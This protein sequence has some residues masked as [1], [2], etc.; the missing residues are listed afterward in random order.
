MG[1]IIETSLN[2][3]GWLPVMHKTTMRSKRIY[4]SW[5]YWTGNYYTTRWDDNCTSDSGH[6]L[7]TSTDN[8]NGMQGE[9]GSDEYEKLTIKDI[10]ER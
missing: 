7:L 5:K 2:M 6:H 8:G 3:R 1:L 10:E 9:D 4:A